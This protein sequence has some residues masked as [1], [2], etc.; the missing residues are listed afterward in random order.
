MLEVSPK[1]GEFYKPANSLVLIPK[2]EPMVMYEQDPEEVQRYDYW[3]RRQR[4]TALDSTICLAVLSTIVIDG[5]VRATK[6]HFVS[7]L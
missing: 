4:T 1:P 7:K 5:K 6:L 2:R 3:K